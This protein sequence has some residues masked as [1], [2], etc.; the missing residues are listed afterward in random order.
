M[1][2][3]HPLPVDPL[4]EAKRQWLA[5]GWADA[6]DGMSLVTSVIRAQQLLLSRVDTA[7]RPFALS[8]ARYEVLRLLAFSRTGTLPLS[9]VVARLQ[10]HPTSV[11]STADRLLR[12]GLIAR[13]RDPRDGRAA[14]LELTD[15][16]RDLVERATTALNQQVFAE[17]GVSPQDTS[18]LIAIVARMRK[19]AGDFA[20]PRPQPDPL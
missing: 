6:A 18:D 17:P 3:A 2:P 16:G 8:F 20:D 19:A 10:V 5:H 14:L 12:D 15:S 7:L 13:H 9:S 11:S 4:A 1:S